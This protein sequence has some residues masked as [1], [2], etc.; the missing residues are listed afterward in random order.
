MK[1][2][3]AIKKIRITSVLVLM[4]IVSLSFIM[5]V[6]DFA[7]GDYSLCVS[8]KQYSYGYQVDIIEHYKECQNGYTKVGKY[9]SY[10]E[11][12]LYADRYSTTGA[13]SGSGGSNSLCNGGY[14]SPTGGDIQ[15]NSFCEYAYNYICVAGYS[16]SSTEVQDLCKTFRTWQSHNSKLGNCKY[17][18]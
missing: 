8:D 7:F 1:N 6:C 10:K 15:S 17:C 2:I 9:S 5:A 11:A 14:V 3:K 18:Q 13:N 4:F 16:P 12:E